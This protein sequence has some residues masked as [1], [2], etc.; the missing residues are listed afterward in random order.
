VISSIG[1]KG[2]VR[3]QLMNFAGPMNHSSPLSKKNK[4]ISIKRK[5]S[6]DVVQKPPEKVQASTGI[7]QRAIK[8]NGAVMGMDKFKLQEKWMLKQNASNRGMCLSNPFFCFDCHLVNLFYVLCHLSMIFSTCYVFL[9][10]CPII[11]V[12]CRTVIKLYYL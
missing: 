3:I 10:T 6:T 11:L 5:S 8:G 7:L 2:Q 1:K 9:Q 4:Q 12:I